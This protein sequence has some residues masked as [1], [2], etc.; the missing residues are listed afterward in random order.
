LFIGDSVG[1][2][3]FFPYTTDASERWGPRAFYWDKGGHYLATGEE[4]K[5]TWLERTKLVNNQ[6]VYD[7]NRGLIPGVGNPSFFCD[8]I[9]NFKG[10]IF[11]TAGVSAARII[12]IAVPKNQSTEYEELRLRTVYPTLDPIYAFPDYVAETGTSYLGVH[13]FAGMRGRWRDPNT[14]A[15]KRITGFLLGYV[16]ETTAPLRLYERYYLHDPN[17]LPEGRRIDQIF[18]GHFRLGLPPY[19]AVMSVEVLGHRPRREFARY[20]Y[21]FVS[22]GKGSRLKFARTAVQKSKAVRDKILLKT[23][24]HRTI[25]SADGLRSDDGHTSGDLILDL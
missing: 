18:A 10:H 15:F 24:L 5:V 2:S 19:N 14:K 3:L 13:I 21:G 16:P 7:Y 11:P 25:S 17:R 20:V 9:G 1:R 23:K 22:D 8:T 4:T 6:I 12:S